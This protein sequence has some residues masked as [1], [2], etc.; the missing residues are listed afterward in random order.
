MMSL[1]FPSARLNTPMAAMALIRGEKVIL[2]FII[3]IFEFFSQEKSTGFYANAK[4]F[5]LLLTIQ[6]GISLSE[7]IISRCL[8]N[9]EIVE[10]RNV[11]VSKSD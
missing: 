10:G 2:W 6:N 9:V 7:R 8:L 4:G 11:T 1:F 5:T 3:H